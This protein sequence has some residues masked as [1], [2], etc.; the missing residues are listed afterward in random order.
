MTHQCPSGHDSETADYCSVCGV[1]LAAAT[2]AMPVSPPAAVAEG[3]DDR[4]PN[5]GSPPGAGATC[6]EC[7][8]PRSAPVTE[9]PWVEQNWEVVVRPDREYYEMLEPDGMEF[10][11]VTASHRFPLVGDLV[12][13]GRRSKRK[14]TQPEIDLSGSMEDTGVSHRHAVLMRRPEGDWALVDQE[15]TNGTYLNADREPVAANQPIP[16]SDGD[17]V[18]VG[19]WTTLTMER[20][21]A[22]PAGHADLDSR[23]SKDTRNLARANRRVEIDLL[24]PLRLRVSGEDVPI[25]APTKRSAKRSVLALLALRV[26][27]PVS[28]LDLEWAVWGEEETKTAVKALQGYVVDLRQV[29]PEDTIETTTPLGYCLR[30]PKDSIDVGRFE[31]RCGRGRALLASGHPGAAVAELTRA[32]EL[33]RGEPLLDLAN[34]PVG[35]TESVRLHELKAEAE[36]DQFEGR[37]QLGEHH[38]LVADLWPAV[39]SEPLRQRRWAQLMLALYRSNRQIE[40]LRAFERLRLEIGERHGLEP[41]TELVALDQ[42]IATNHA[43]LQWT[44][45]TEAVAPTTSVTTATARPA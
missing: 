12:S 32:L 38:S 36:E 1:P 4:C 16:L 9:A 37:L 15:S 13:I 27:T 39:E 35:T 8:Y 6:S 45:P 17:R 20:R 26:G 34:G 23:P 29:L 41:S 18:H 44:P 25:G 22:G 3:A 2:T 30:V 28:A 7:G 33:W 19:A 10:P 5:C 40:A 31:R 24:G 42:A 11:E 21:D 43:D 14:A